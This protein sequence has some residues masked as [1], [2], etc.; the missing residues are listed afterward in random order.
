M[1]AKLKLEMWVHW[2]VRVAR[3]TGRGFQFTQKLEGMFTDMRI[4]AEAANSFRNYVTRQGVS[5]LSSVREA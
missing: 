3:L 5:P 4:S 1:V 2:V